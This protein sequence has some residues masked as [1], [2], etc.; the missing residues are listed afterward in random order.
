MELDEIKY[1]TYFYTAVVVVLFLFS[2][3]GKEKSNEFGDLELV[4]N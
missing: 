1:Y 3:N 2:T 4:K